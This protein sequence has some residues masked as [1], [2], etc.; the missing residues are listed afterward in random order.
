MVSVVLP[1]TAF[2]LVF[3]G[4][5]AIGAGVL[6]ARGK[7]VAGVLLNL[8]WV[9]FFRRSKWRVADGYF[10]IATHFK[11]S[12]CS[13]AAL[14]CPVAFLLCSAFYVL[15][16]PLGLLLTFH[17]GFQLGGLWIGLTAGLIYSSIGAVWIGIVRADWEAEVERA[18]AR[19]RGKG[20]GGKEED[21]QR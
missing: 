3:D 2:S 10:D 11:S 4:V 7:Q 21:A 13:I 18:R 14:C 17:F 5:N 8:R 12:Y 20:N 6:R 15:G 16:I 19:V 1:I 9:T